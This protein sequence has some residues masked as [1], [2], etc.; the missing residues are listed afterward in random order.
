MPGKKG[1]KPGE[2]P[3]QRALAAAVIVVNDQVRNLIVKNKK[4]V[5]LDGFLYLEYF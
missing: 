3:E 4:P 1:R 5:H 2:M